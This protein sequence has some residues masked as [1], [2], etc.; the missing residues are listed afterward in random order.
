MGSIPESRRTPEEGNDNPLQYFCLV[1]PI[2]RGGAWQAIVHGSTE[3]SGMTYQLNNNNVC[4]KLISFPLIPCGFV[5][6][7]TI[8]A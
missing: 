1:R 2:N 4:V 3:E 6:P 8:Q 7:N 5:Y